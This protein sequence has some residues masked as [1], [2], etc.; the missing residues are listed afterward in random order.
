MCRKKYSVSTNLVKHINNLVFVF[1]DLKIGALL[2]PFMFYFFFVFFILEIYNKDNSTYGHCL[3]GLGK[4]FG[5]S[6]MKEF[7]P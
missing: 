4:I 2:F 7:L 1:G 5:E 3:Q 6:N